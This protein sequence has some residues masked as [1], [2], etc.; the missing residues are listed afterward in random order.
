MTVMQVATLVAINI[1][2][3][4]GVAALL[5]ARKRAQ[6]SDVNAFLKWAVRGVAVVWLF[7][8]IWQYDYLFGSRG[9]VWNPS[10]DDQFQSSPTPSPR[11]EVKV[12]TPKEISKEAADEHHDEL[13]DFAESFEETDVE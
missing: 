11:P 2:F 12:R 13:K 1:V 4:F 7:T 6:E 10:R 5:R 9:D 8:L 3:A